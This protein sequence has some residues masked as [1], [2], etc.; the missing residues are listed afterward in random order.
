MDG[1]ARGTALVIL[2]VAVPLLVTSMILASRG[3]VRGLVSWIGTISF[4]LYNSLLFLF[5]TPFNGL[6][7]LYCAMCSLAIW[8]A[9]TTLNPSRV[10]EFASH[11]GRG[12]PARG[13]AVYLWAIAGLNALAWL[14]RIVPELASGKR[15]EFVIGTGLPTNPIFVLDLTFWIP[16][17]AISALWLWRRRPWGY[18]LAGTVLVYGVVESVTIAVDQYM[19]HAADPASNV[20]SDALTMPFLVLALIGLIPLTLY[21]RHLHIKTAFPSSRRP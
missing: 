12:L 9:M 17:T 14:A 2:V 11:F 3:S 20:A 15:P 13:I 8:A 1:S 21:M 4:L 5:T 10:E 18:L 16:L 7:L 19:G 6:F